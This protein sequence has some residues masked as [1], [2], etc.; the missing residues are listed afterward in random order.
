MIATGGVHNAIV[1]HT[2]DAVLVVD[3]ARAQD[4]KRVVDALKQRYAD[5][6][7]HQSV[8]MPTN[9]TRPWGTYT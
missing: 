7:H 1:V 4:A 5:S 9:V 8:I 3:N 2:P 6:D